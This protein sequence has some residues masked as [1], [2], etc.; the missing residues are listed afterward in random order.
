METIFFKETK[1][2]IEKY[3]LT[4]NEQELIQLQEI[5]LRKCCPVTRK[6]LNSV[7]WPKETSW[8]KNIQRGRE[9]GV[10]EHECEPDEPI[11]EY[12]YDEYLPSDL[13]KQIDNLWKGTKEEKLRGLGN[14]FIKSPSSLERMQEDIE[15]LSQEIDR[16][17]NK[18]P[19]K[20][21][22][23]LKELQTLL[24]IIK[25]NENLESEDKYRKQAQE[26]IQITLIDTIEKKEA[27][28]VYAF[29]EIPFEMEKLTDPLK[30]K[31]VKKK[32]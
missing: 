4:Y 17:S 27:E 28:R 25:K 2:T 19:E 13:A 20:K 7:S 12:T 21:I 14:L 26:C 32:N 3:Q 6:K 29:F 30:R 16:I 22:K 5:I 18:E 11:Y 23:K 9:V 24:E 31:R 10:K 15:A 8:I 1:N